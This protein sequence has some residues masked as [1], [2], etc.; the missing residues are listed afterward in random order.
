M[1]T[2]HFCWDKMSSSKASFFVPYIIHNFLV[3]GDCSVIHP[4]LKLLEKIQH[5][6]N[7]LWSA[8]TIL[9]IE[10]WNLFHR[11]RWFGGYFSSDFL[12]ANGYSLVWVDGLDSWNPLMKGIVTWVYPIESQT[13][14]WWI[15]WFMIWNG[16]QIPWPFGRETFWTWQVFPTFV[17]IKW[18][19]QRMDGCWW[20]PIFGMEI[21]PWI[22]GNDLNPFIYPPQVG[23]F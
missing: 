18:P 19:F 23:I 7:S 5:L 6:L 8:A 2:E 22:S 11:N 20:P 10:W 4:N 1:E 15:S 3:W 9:K 17:G 21:R 14:N 16:Q 13:T 12:S